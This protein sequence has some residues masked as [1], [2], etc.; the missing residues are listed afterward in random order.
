MSNDL[1]GKAGAVSED[2]VY[3]DMINRPFPSIT[4]TTGQELLIVV[5]AI[6]LSKNGT[7]VGRTVSGTPRTKIAG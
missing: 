2:I 6:E 3:D 4:L 5:K 7:D 1:I